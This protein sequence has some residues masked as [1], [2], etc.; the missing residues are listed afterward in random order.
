MVTIRQITQITDAHCGP[1]VVQML[2]E[3]VE[4][5]VTQEAVA[6]EGEAEKDLNQYGM[7]VDQ[8]ALA[9]NRLAPQVRFWYKYRGDI[10]DLKVIIRR[11]YGVA[12]EWQG[13]FYETEEEEQEEDPPDF[14]DRGHYS[15]A[16]SVD[17]EYEEMVFVDPHRQFAGRKRLFSLP[18]FLRRWWDKNYQ[19]EPYTGEVKET[20]DEGLLFFITPASETFP[21]DLGCKT[22]FEG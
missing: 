17:E 3:P 4:V 13:L 19:V 5:F 10:S 16:V 1:A 21:Y 7:R 12:V 22:F 9:V 6:R 15:I 14:D 8:M 20:R 18:V 11:G 2:L